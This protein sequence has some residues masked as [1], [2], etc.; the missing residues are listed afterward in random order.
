MTLQV[1]AT[2]GEVL[3]VSRLAMDETHH[4]I[5]PGLKI[6]MA[7]KA[8]VKSTCGHRRWNE[9]PAVCGKTLPAAGS[10]PV[11]RRTP[12]IKAAAQ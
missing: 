6:S 2:L 12:I 3:D 9:A 7:G 11:P 10:T 8:G 5:P 1:W 4:P